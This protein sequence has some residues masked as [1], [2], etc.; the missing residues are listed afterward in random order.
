MFKK[1]GMNYC[2]NCFLKFILNDIQMVFDNVRGFN[3]IFL[4]LSVVN[5]NCNIFYCYYTC[6]SMVV[7]TTLIK[8][9]ILIYAMIT[10][11]NKLVCVYFR[12]D[13]EL[14]SKFKRIIIFYRNTIF[15]YVL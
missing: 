14:L 13:L 3:T 6:M 5:Y 7:S 9:N 10:H 2:G 11:I 8:C 12:F 1:H 4:Q 15:Y